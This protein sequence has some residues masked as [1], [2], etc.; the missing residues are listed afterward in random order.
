MRILVVHRYFWPDTP[1]Y[2]AILRRIVDRWHADG[3]EVEV[4]SSQPSYK[5]GIENRRRP[6]CELV[7]G[8]SIRRLSLAPEAGRPA[9]RIWNALRLSAALLWRAIWKRYDLIMISTVP[10]VIGGAAAALSARL[11]GARF[12][13]HCMDIHP[14]VGR[15]SGEFSNPFVFRTLS[16]LDSWSCRKADPIVVLSGDM[17]RTLRERKHGEH[18][19]IRVLNNFSLPSE[20]RDPVSP[21]FEIAAGKLTVLFA[22]N[23]GR[24]QGLESAV[25]AMGRIRMRDDVE[26]VLMGEGVAKPELQRRAGML[27]A[28][29]RFVGHQPVAVAKQAMQMADFGFVSLTPGLY[30]YAYPSK[31]MTYLEQGCPLIVAVESSSELASAVKERKFGYC[32]PPGDSAALAE[33]LSALADNRAASKA[34]RESARR[35]WE[36]RYSE[37]VMLEKWSELCR[38]SGSQSS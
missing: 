4:L 35:E 14:E 37:T 23:I 21:P 30:R 5:G 15:V 34:L 17:E 2:A 3:H 33:M 20:N 32:V 9:L 26:L 28:N 13:Y 12:I 8:V 18:F 19:R 16:W 38:H 11:T 36:S 29:V 27:K 31:T 22:G 24:F 7:D 25:E 6:R 1:P 10:P